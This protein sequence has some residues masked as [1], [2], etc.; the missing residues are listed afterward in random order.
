MLSFTNLEYKIT[1]NYSNIM[2]YYFQRKKLC[3]HLLVGGALF[4]AGLGMFS[5]SDTYDLDTKQPTDVN[6]KGLQ[7]IYGYMESQGN[8]GTFM[9]LIKDLGQDEILS[10]TGSKTLFVADD[11]AFAEFFKSNK[12]GVTSYSQLSEAQKKMLLYSAMIDNPYTTSMLS[13]AAGVGTGSPTRG[14]ACRRNSSLAIYDSV[15]VVNTSSDIL[16]SNPRFDDLRANHPGE[17]IVMFTDNSA[18]SPMVHFTAKYI[19]ANKITYGDIDFL[20]NDK[21][22]TLA[23]DPREFLCVNN[24]RV[25][26]IEDDA[27]IFCKN[28]FV[29]KVDRVIVPL[30]NMAEII[31]KD[32]QS[33]IY[34]SIIERYAALD[35]DRTLT[36]AYNN[37]KGTDFDS[38]FIKRYYSERTYGSTVSTPKPFE[39]DKNGIKIEGKLKFDPGWNTYI[40]SLFSDRDAMMEDMAVMLVP[41]DEAMT[42]WWNEG[43]G[44]VIKDYYGTLDAT[45]LTTLQDLVNVNMIESFNSAVPSHFNSVLN[46][47]NERLGITESDI[48]R[49]TIG[50]N[51]VIYHTKKVFAPTSY[52]SVLFPAVVDT[53]N[54][55]VVKK[56]IDQ[57]DYKAYLNSMVSTYSFFLPTNDG[58]LTY[59]DPVSYGASTSNMWLFKYDKASDNI[60]AEVWACEFNG[61]QWVR[62]GDTFVNRV[63]WKSN[64]AIGCKGIITNTSG[65]P[66]M[67]DRMEEILDNCIVI[68]PLV[69][70]KKYYKTKGNCF[71]K[72]E[73]TV[74]DKNS[75]KVYGSGQN[76]T[77]N[78]LTVSHIYNMNNGKSYVVDGPIMGTQKSV[79]ASLN[80][81]PE[82]SEFLSVLQ[83][84]GAVNEKNTKDSWSAASSQ[85][86]FGNL[87]N[88]KTYGNVGA[89][90]RP[91]GSNASGKATYLLNNYHYTVYAPTND[92]MEKAYA[93]GL[94]RPSL[95]DEMEEE[96]ASADER[97]VSSDSIQTEIDKVKEAML[98]FVKYHIQDN[99]IYMD[100]GFESGAYETAK[101]ELIKSTSVAERVAEEDLVKYD[102][103]DKALDEF[104]TYTVTYYVGKYTPGRPYKLNVNVSSSSMTVKDNIGQTHNV[105]PSLS[106]IMAREYWVKASSITSPYTVQL[107]NSSSVVI[108]GIDGPL[109]YDMDQFVYKYK[110]LDSN[111]VKPRR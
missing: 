39:E 29:H 28:G 108:Q 67:T 9:Q 104:G 109:V 96:L 57:L 71:V 76:E 74:N 48:A 101:T 100:E 70:G 77:G 95:I 66:I 34:S 20:F 53:T 87:F 7:S 81:Y 90:D 78:P 50:C 58:L 69:A 94:P 84:S 63:G 47:A 89:E 12:W 65:D 26:N 86:G 36:D 45:P 11:N 68:E 17:D 99:S 15:L 33:K 52:S 59:V 88:Y 5:C 24:A 82:F 60:Y 44:S 22:G 79:A 56:A 83:Y 106:N 30:D 91:A 64:K 42:T 105:V 80:E 43:G 97:G 98:D 38:V 14:E 25:T 19:G 27:N 55:K 10:K 16:P 51:G 31:R 62:T 32:E 41:T 6:G 3:R 46:D 73:G 1:K 4:A 92:A 37:N 102:I 18:A 8:Y 93:L 111:A 23:K 72:V 110:P 75:M 54:F 40:P 85:P 2:L 35:Y 103:K 107:E 61:T 49:V 21:S 13:N